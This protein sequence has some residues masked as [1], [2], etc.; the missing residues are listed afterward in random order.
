MA[1]NASVATSG[2]KAACW[3][4]PQT[5]I[6]GPTWQ[7]CIR[8]R[9]KSASGKQGEYSPFALRQPPVL[10]TSQRR[11]TE[12]FPYTSAKDKGDVYKRQEYDEMEDLCKNMIPALEYFGENKFIEEVRENRNI[13]CLAMWEEKTIR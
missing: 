6:F 9:Y 8:D 7:M 5:R 1:S 3:G 13:E 12:K 11:S 4:S 2:T 10:V